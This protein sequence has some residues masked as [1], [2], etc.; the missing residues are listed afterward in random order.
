MSEVVKTIVKQ[1]QAQNP[2]WRTEVPD[3]YDVKAYKLRRHGLD[4]E[5]IYDQKG[6][7]W[8]QLIQVLRSIMRRARGS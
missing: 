1:I 6:F 4:V 8:D 5:T 2:L 7:Y 3:V